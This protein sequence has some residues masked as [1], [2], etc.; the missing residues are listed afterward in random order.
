MDYRDPLL[1]ALL[2]ALA[3]VAGYLVVWVTWP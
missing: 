1:A 3:Q 2:C